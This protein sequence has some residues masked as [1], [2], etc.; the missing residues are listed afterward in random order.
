MPPL[1]GCPEAS[2]Q[3]AVQDFVDYLVAASDNGSRHLVVTADSGGGY[4]AHHALA[5]SPEAARATKH[6][7][8]MSPML[9]AVS[10]DQCSDEHDAIGS[11]ATYRWCY[12]VARMETPVPIGITDHGS[13]ASAV[14]VFASDDE[15]LSADA[16]LLCQE[17]QG[18]GIPIHEKIMPGCFHSWPTMVGL[19]IPECDDAFDHIVGIVESIDALDNKLCG[20]V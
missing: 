19:D 6:A 16:R 12:Q 18:K 15:V 11:L 17:L 2:R 10:L 5:S 3:D 13:Y 20:A 4:V 7:V 8:L 14:T 9:G 1:P